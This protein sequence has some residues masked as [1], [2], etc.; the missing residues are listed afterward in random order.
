MIE[1]RQV[2]FGSAACGAKSDDGGSET[3]MS[4]FT[5]PEASPA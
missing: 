2:A 3:S 4:S 1:P 5:P